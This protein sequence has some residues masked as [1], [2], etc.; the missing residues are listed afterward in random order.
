MQPGT[1][2]NDDVYLEASALAPEVQRRGAGGVQ[3]AFEELRDNERFE[4][5]AAQRVEGELLHGVYP[6]EPGS[7]AGIGE[8]QFRC[9][10]QAL[11]ERLTSPA[12]NGG[13]PLDLVEHGTVPVLRQESA[14][15]RMRELADV[16]VLQRDVGQVIEYG[17]GE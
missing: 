17:A 13:H 9:P 10:Y 6:K 8:V 12:E 3:P 2:F 1:F 11:Q 5:G 4:K 16:R 15:I 7:E 14:G